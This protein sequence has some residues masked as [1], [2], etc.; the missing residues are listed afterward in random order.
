MVGPQIAITKNIGR[1]KFG[2]LVRDRHTYI[3]KYEIL[4]DFNLVVAKLDHQTAKFNS[5]P[6][7]PS[8][9]YI[10]L[11]IPDHCNSVY[12]SELLKVEGTKLH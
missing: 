4:V 10:P 5:P 6:N 2:S 8:I 1:F 3:C 11:V 9:R 7:F 12:C